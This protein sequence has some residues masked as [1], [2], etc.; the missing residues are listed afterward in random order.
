[1]Q[2]AFEF[3]NREFV[4]KQQNDFGWDWGPGFSPTG[5]WQPAWVVQLEREEEVYVRNSVFD[6]YRVGQVNNIPPDQTADW[7]FNA[8]VDVLGRV[9]QGVKLT[10][11][12]VDAVTGKGVSRGELMNVSVSDSGDVVTGTTI[13]DSEQYKLWWPVGLGEQNLYN[14]SVGVLYG[15]ATIATVKKRMGFRTIVLNLGEI[16]EEQRALGIAPGNNC[17]CLLVLF[18]L[19][20]NPGLLADNLSS[21]G[22][23]RSTATSSMPKAATS[24]LR[25]LSGP[26]SHLKGYGSYLTLLSMEIKTCLG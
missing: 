14:I 7:V 22:T 24:F 3:G 4:R 11:E 17:M 12:I 13:L 1:M 8:S 26:E 18:Q 21:Q 2:N 23:S 19:S 15:D 16:T 20:P 9:P 25:T 6:L 5:I 10:Y